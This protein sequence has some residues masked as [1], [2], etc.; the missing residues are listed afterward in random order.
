MKKEEKKYLDPKDMNTLKESSQYA[1]FSNQTD[2]MKLTF[3]LLF[4]AYYLLPT[5]Y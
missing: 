3:Y 2:G 5:V 4:T 1:V